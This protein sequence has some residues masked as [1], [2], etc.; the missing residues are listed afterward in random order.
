MNAAII[1][2]IR[3]LQQKGGSFWLELSN[4]RVVQIYSSYSVATNETIV[5]VL[6]D[7][8][9]ELLVAEHITAVGT[10]VH[11]QVQKQLRERRA[12][13][14]KRFEENKKN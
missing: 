10:G 9:F 3:A 6:H 13:A 4:A 11:S 14:M 1:D 5:A 8:D 7:D 12:E 2:Q